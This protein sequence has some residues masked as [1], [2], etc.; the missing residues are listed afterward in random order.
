MIEVSCWNSHQHLKSVEKPWEKERC[1]CMCLIQHFSKNPYTVE[2]LL[3][4]F[5]GK[6]CREKQEHSALT[7][8][9]SSRLSGEISANGRRTSWATR[10]SLSYYDPSVGQRDALL[11]LVCVLCFLCSRKRTFKWVYFEKSVDML[12]TITLGDALSHVS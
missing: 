5:G 10:A 12:S 11:L 3:S 8:I 1:V 9:P 6:L 4:L 7:I 2:S